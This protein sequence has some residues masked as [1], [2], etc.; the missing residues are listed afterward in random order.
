MR[1]DSST[2]KL[3]EQFRGVAHLIHTRTNARMTSAGLSLARF[4]VL[5]ALHDSGAMRMNQLS[6][7]LGVV[8]RT[9]TTLVDAME[10]EGLLRRLSD[11]NDRRV[12][13]LELTKEGVR[14]F[15]QLRTTHDEVA[16]ELFR[17]LTKVE[18]T[19][20]ARLLDRLEAGDPGGTGGEFGHHQHDH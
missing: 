13:R 17:S 18:K 20:L 9:V 10:E 16:T 3:M 19:Q 5:T 1:V 8:P 2:V 7:A 4:R 15:D 6:T 12:T 11:P 14:Q